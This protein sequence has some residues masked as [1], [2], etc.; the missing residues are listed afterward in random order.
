MSRWICAVVPSIGFEHD[1]EHCET[2]ARRLA[3]DTLFGG[4]A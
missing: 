4:A 2:I 3:Q 1:E